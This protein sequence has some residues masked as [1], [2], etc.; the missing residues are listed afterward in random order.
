MRGSCACYS[1]NP[2]GKSKWQP[3][4]CLKSLLFSK[5]ARVL[6]K[7]LLSCV[8]LKKIS[9]FVCG[10]LKKLFSLRVW[11][12]AQ[13]NFL[14]CS[15]WKKKTPFSIPSLIY[16]ATPL[17]NYACDGLFSMESKAA[18]ME[19][20]ILSSKKNPMQPRYFLIKN[21]VFH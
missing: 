21:S 16:M 1:E 4:L 13:I 17:F 9:L 20:M 3:S 19:C 5:S 8:D 12:S 7:T 10:S 18:N 15:L 11:I 2:L 14:V 6:S